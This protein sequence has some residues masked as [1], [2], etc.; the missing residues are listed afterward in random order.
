M[1]PA[2]HLT[3]AWTQI[4]ASEVD[5]VQENSIKQRRRLA[6]NSTERHMI[7][8]VH[9]SIVIHCSTLFSFI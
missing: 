7:L 8:S 3:A 2:T 5:T 1:S 9:I 6:E 4:Q